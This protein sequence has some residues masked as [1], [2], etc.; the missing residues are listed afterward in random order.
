MER[1]VFSKE[2]AC[3]KSMLR[4][5]MDL[6]ELS[7]KYFGSASDGALLQVEHTK[8]IAW[9]NNEIFVFLEVKTCKEI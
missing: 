8:R 5:W 9:V 6:R 2:N 1:Y 7:Y 4:L 3:V